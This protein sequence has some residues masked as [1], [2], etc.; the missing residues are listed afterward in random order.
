[1]NPII[2]LPPSNGNGGQQ[3]GLLTEF[4]VDQPLTQR[5]GDVISIP[6]SFEGLTIA[7][8]QL[9]I[10]FIT[11]RAWL[12]GTVGW[13]ALTGTPEVE[14]FITRTRPGG[15]EEIIF[16]TRDEADA[17]TNNNAT[18]GF[19]F[20]DES[21]IL[22]QGQQVIVYRL[23]VRNISQSDGAQIDGPIIFTAAEIRSNP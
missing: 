2:N 8:V 12:N 14:F 18:T 4:D 23:K 20:V 19:T 11:D 3:Q 21:P 7:T 15:T 17:E 6:N 13:D 10:D 9:V 1:V 16:L 22:T 5:N